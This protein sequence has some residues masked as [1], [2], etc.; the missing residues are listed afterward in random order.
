MI[1]K[2]FELDKKD[3]SKINFCL[4]YGENEGL[5]NDIINKIKNKHSGKE[6][7]YEET[8]VLKNIHDFYGE[9]KNKS[10][11]DE[12]RIYIID[13]CTEK[14]L[15]IAEEI[16]EKETNDLIIINCGILDKRSKLRNLIEKSIQTI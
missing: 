5:K 6:I 16:S 7:K 3:I 8:Y 9:I 4:I 10:L 1:F 15:E 2:S 14:I 13:R 12:K 11:F